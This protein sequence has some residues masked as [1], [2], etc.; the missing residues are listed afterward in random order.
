MRTILRFLPPRPMRSTWFLAAR[1]APVL[2]TFSSPPIPTA[3]HR[4]SGYVVFSHLAISHPIPQKR[5]VAALQLDLRRNATRCTPIIAEANQNFKCFSSQI[6]VPA[7]VCTFANVAFAICTFFRH[8][9]L[10]F[11]R[12]ADVFFFLPFEG[13]EPICLQLF[14]H[15]TRQLEARREAHQR[16]FRQQ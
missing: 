14:R 2:T 12:M 10:L 6:L 4:H 9:V 1:P 11:R 3:I 8:L 13:V 15:A 7:P 16:G 5:R